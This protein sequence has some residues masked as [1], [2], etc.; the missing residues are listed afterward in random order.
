[1]HSQTGALGG[2]AALRSSVR[3]ECLQTTSKQE[4]QRV[5]GEDRSTL[6]RVWQQDERRKTTREGSLSSALRRCASCFA[7]LARTFVHGS[8][9]RSRGGERGQVSR[10]VRARVKWAHALAGPHTSRPVASGP[11]PTRRGAARRAR[12]A[13]WRRF[14]RKVT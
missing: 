12:Q 11:A 3:Q 10:D 6:G 7:G 9:E 13:A 5:R 1:M 14:R 8:E 2:A 4:Q